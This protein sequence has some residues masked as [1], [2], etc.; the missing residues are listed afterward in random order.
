MP[1]TIRITRILDL[2]P[3]IIN[4]VGI[5]SD[6]VTSEHD[7]GQ[8]RLNR[9]ALEVLDRRGLDRFSCLTTECVLVRTIIISVP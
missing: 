9:F 4:H 7:F 3:S 5:I 8:T 6:M 2:F 1:D